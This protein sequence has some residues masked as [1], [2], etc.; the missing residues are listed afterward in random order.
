MRL[1]LTRPFHV[2]I[3]SKAQFE[4]LGHKVIWYEL[5]KIESIKNEMPNKNYDGYII[6]SLHAVSALTNKPEK[7]IITTGEATAAEVKKLGF[8]NV[9]SANG[10]AS[11]V[12]KRR[13][14]AKIKMFYTFAPKSRHESELLARQNISCNPG[15]LSGKRCKT[16]QSASAKRIERRHNRWG[17]VYSPRTARFGF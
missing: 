7:P 6:T 5:L 8:Q 16:F 1:L 17:A 15:R 13:S 10:D 11:M 9:I 2:S 3:N 14:L 4:A 12:A